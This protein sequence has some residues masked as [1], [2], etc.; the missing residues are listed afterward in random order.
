MDGC[1]YANAPGISQP[2]EARRNI[3]SITE[4]MIALR[5]D[6]AEVH[7]YAKLEPPSFRQLSVTL[8]KGLLNV[9]R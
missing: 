7:A 4:N 9:N 1:G 8:L 6:I 2:F 5:H 3:H